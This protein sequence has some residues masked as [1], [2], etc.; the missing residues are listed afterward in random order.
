MDW[1]FAQ[2]IL[3][4]FLVKMLGQTLDLPWPCKSLAVWLMD[5]MDLKQLFSIISKQASKQSSKQVNK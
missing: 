4:F 5:E 1:L 3:D 2:G